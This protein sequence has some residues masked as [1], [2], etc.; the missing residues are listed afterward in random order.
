MVDHS[1]III[2]GKSWWMISP[3]SNMSKTH[4]VVRPKME[5]TSKCEATAV[6]IHHQFLIYREWNKNIRNRE[7]IHSNKKKWKHIFRHQYSSKPTFP[8][9]FLGFSP[10]FVNF[11]QLFPPSLALYPPGARRSL[12]NFCSTGPQV[13]R[14]RAVSEKSTGP[15]PKQSTKQHPHPAPTPYPHWLSRL[16]LP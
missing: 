13:C 4:M 8:P 16:G 11:S 3:W 6:G 15:K 5:S 10:P 7:T 12:M 1:Y 9:V 2:D 14:R